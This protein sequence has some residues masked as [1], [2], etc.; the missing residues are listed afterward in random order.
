[1]ATTSNSRLKRIVSEVSDARTRIKSHEDYITRHETRTRA[2]LIDPLLGSLGWDIKDP[3]RVQLELPTKGGIPDYILIS[4]EGPEAVVEAKP[5][6]EGLG[7]YEAQLFAQMMDPCLLQVKVGVLVSGNEWRFYQK[8]KL[9]MEQLEVVSGV[10]WEIA[11]E[12]E[13]R[14]AFW[15]IAPPVERRLTEEFPDGMDP[16]R[17]IIEGRST[18]LPKGTWKELYV[19]VAKHLVASGRIRPGSEPIRLPKAKN[20]LINSSGVHPPSER[21]PRGK[22]FVV[23]VDIGEEFVLEANVPRQ[24]AIDNSIFL[25]QNCGIDPSNVRVQFG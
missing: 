12:L 5:L 16:T 2:L 20:H 4:D 1:M 21:Y 23:P 7:N 11:V 19:A 18:K 24:G 9:K 15:N 22:R 10:S 17:V 8:P 3:N 6:F 25:L 13:Q 14:L